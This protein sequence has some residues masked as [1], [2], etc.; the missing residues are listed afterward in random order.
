MKKAVNYLD[1]GKGKKKKKT[2]PTQLSTQKQLLCE[3]RLTSQWCWGIQG[4][5]R[6]ALQRCPACTFGWESTPV[7]LGG[8]SWFRAVCRWLRG[9]EETRKH[10]WVVFFFF[11]HRPVFERQLLKVWHRSCY[12]VLCYLRLNLRIQRCPVWVLGQQRSMLQIRNPS[13]HSYRRNK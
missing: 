6:H 10:L 3:T 9:T 8:L 12:R 11:L 1:D 7:W 4:T 13:P 5:Q 2:K